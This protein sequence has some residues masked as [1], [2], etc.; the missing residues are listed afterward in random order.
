MSNKRKIEWLTDIED[1]N[2]VKIT[3]T[4]VGREAAFDYLDN[5]DMIVDKLECPAPEHKL[6]PN[7]EEFSVISEIHLDG[8]DEYNQ[9]R[10]DFDKLIE[11]DYTIDCDME[12]T[13]NLH[14]KGEK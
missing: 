14:L 1:P 7:D 12:V 10:E 5:I 3:A 8:M 13:L 4:I 2:I 6:I 9:F 11:L